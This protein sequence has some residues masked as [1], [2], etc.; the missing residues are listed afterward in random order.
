MNEIARYIRDIAGN[1][2]DFILACKVTA[3]DDKTCDVVPLDNSAPLKKVK[4]NAAPEQ[5]KGIVIT[6]VVDSVVL[7][8]LRTE[9]DASILMFSEI[10][11]IDIILSEDIKLSL[12]ADEIV[13]N[14]NFKN[15]FLIDINKLKTKINNIENDINTLKN[16]FTAW[17]PAPMD[18]G[19]VLKT[20]SS[21]W[22]VQKLTPTQVNDIKDEKIKH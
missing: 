17:V 1:A 15:S 12:N 4:L 13:F 10:E 18:G 20:A 16:I 3:V 8:G 11:K 22:A 2:D 6:P 7:V 5:G 21:A 19:A 14:D 9:T